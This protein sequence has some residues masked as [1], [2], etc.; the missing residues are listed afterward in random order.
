MN[1]PIKIMKITIIIIREVIQQDTQRMNIIIN[2]LMVTGMLINKTDME[3][4]ITLKKLVVIMKNTINPIII[5]ILIRISKN[6]KSNNLLPAGIINRMK[7]QKILMKKSRTIIM[8]KE[9]MK[10][11]HMIN[12]VVEIINLSREKSMT[13]MIEIKIIIMTMINQGVLEGGRATIKVDIV[14]LKFRN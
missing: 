5:K 11:S 9:L 7:N 8:K 12:M 13:N 4:I 10:R 2:L 14:K 3:I 1:F 6:T